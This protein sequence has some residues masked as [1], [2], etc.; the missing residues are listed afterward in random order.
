MIRLLIVHEAPVFCKVIA[1]ALEQEPD[2]SIAGLA[3]TVEEALAQLNQSDVV[4]VCTSLPDN[5]SLTLTRAINKVNPAVKVLV[6]GVPKAEETILQY[7][8]AGAGA[9]V[10]T[11]DSLDELLQNIRA[12][13]KGEALASPQIIAALM[14]RITQLADLHVRYSHNLDGSQLADLTPREREV[15]DLMGQGLSN[16]AIADRLTIELG[17]VKNHVHNILQKLGVANRWE[18]IPYATLLTKDE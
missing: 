4:L 12:V 16:P 11:E 6:L 1:A 5:G 17:T 14:A 9:Y 15:L 3:T 10:L 7:I 2:I 13:Q 8:E 18:A